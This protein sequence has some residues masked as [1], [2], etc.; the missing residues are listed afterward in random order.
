MKKQ[1][2]YRRAVQRLNNIYNLANADYF[3]GEL[4]EATVTIQESQRGNL[5][6]ICNNTKSLNER[7]LRL[8]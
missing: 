8:D 3:G 2:S 5:R 6:I 4:P 7:R 1:D